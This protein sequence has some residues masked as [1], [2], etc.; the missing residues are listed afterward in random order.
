MLG[1]ANRMSLSLGG[2]N[3][4]G[5]VAIASRYFTQLTDAGSKYFTV[6]KYTLA[7]GDTVEF[8]YQAP[9]AVDTAFFFDGDTSGDAFLITNYGG[10]TFNAQGFETTML[11]DGVSVSTTSVYPIDGK[12]HT[13]V[14]TSNNTLEIAAIGARYDGLFTYEGKIFDFI[15]RNSSGVAQR[16]YKIDETWAD[17]STVLVDYATTLGSEEITNGDFSANV[18]DWTEVSSTKSFDDGTCEV[19]TAAAGGIRQ[20]FTTVIG[21]TYFVTY[22]TTSSDVDNQVKIGTNLT[23]DIYIGPLSAVPVSRIAVFTAEKT[24]TTVYFRN[25]AAG[26]VNWDN[27]S[28]KQASGYGTAVNITDA[29]ADQFTK[30]GADWL[31]VDMVVNGNFAT[32]S[33]WTVPASA[34][35]TGGKCV[36]TN[37]TSE[38][39]TQ[40]MSDSFVIGNIYK[41]TCSLIVDSGTDY[42]L[43]YD[44][45]VANIVTVSSTGEKIHTFEAA[46]ATST[47]YTSFA[48]ASFNGSI[49]NITAKQ[50]LEGV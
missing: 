16:Y 41:T 11:L 7:V 6:P 9:T 27:I 48:Q 50:F 5:G 21:E 49:D 28:V 23:G 3:N 35:I 19:V 34:E 45:N 10:G 40:T 39:L 30:S 13:I 31:G 29:D 25:N 38:F 14:L 8:S 24:T 26:T 1:L 37:S 44:G 36:F 15:I 4:G 22:T 43:P 47:L 32:D 42:R 12:L 17:G 46:S 18:D 33:D 2:A 20:S